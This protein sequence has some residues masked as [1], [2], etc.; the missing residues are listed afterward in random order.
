M[1]LLSLAL[2]S[3]L[4]FAASALMTNAATIT[5]GSF[6][7]EQYVEHTP[8]TG[9]VRSSEV[10]VTTLGGYRYMT[11]T[12]NN[13]RAGGT[14]LSSYEGYLD[15]SNAA[16]T[17]GTGTVTWDGQGSTGLGG[18][19]LTSAGTNDALFLD[20][21]FADANLV[22]SFTIRDTLGAISTITTT[23]AETLTD[24]TSLTFLFSSFTGTA[25]FAL[26]DSIT[27]TLSGTTQG[28]DAS[29]DT[30]YAG[31]TQPEVAPVPL[32]AAGFLLAGGVLALGAA[33]RRKRNAA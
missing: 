4:A 3:G 14:S 18:V 20:V 22:L 15:F 7:T 17:S 27:L 31:S 16:R 9:N 19:D 23:V 12:N 24:P 25:N 32:P 21:V 5:I 29:I 2:T 13:S 26:V 30:V 28:L 1:R 6:D 8:R 11:V 33:K 10:A